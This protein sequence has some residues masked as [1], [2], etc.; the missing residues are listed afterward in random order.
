MMKNFIKLLA[1]SVILVGFSATT[2]AQSAASAS[3]SATLI[4]PLTITKTQDLNF[5]SLASSATAGTAVV[6]PETGGVSVTGG[7]TDPGTVAHM[8]ATFTVAGQASSTITVANNVTE[9]T[10]DKGSGPTLTVNTFTY[11][12]DG[13]T[14]GVQTFPGS[15]EIAVGGSSTLTVGA[16]MNIPATTAAG[17]YASTGDFTIT[18][19]YN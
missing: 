15:A 5:G 1:I 11:A 17:T 19:N 13:T 6:N 18:I 2:F 8:A 3:S 9:V 12:M 7:V 14:G 4:A 16:T 10:L